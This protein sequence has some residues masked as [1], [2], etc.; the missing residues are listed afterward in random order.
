MTEQNSTPVTPTTPAPE[1]PEIKPDNI[2]QE[3]GIYP[4]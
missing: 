3:S 1:I 2:I 4:E